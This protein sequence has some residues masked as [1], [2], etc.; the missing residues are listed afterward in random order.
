[1]NPKDVDF[2]L[3][4]LLMFKPNKNTSQYGFVINFPHQSLKISYE[5][6][7]TL[8][9]FV[10]QNLALY[11]VDRKNFYINNN[12]PDITL[13]EI[14]DKMVA[15]IFPVVFVVNQ[16]L[17]IVNLENHK[18]IVAR[19]EQ[20]KTTMASYYIGEV[21]E[22][23]MTNFTNHYSNPSLLAKQLQKDWWYFI[24]FPTLYQYYGLKLYT[25]KT[26]TLTFQENKLDLDI[27]YEIEKQYS[28]T[29]KLILNLKSEPNNKD[30]AAYQARYMLNPEANTIASAVGSIQYLE[31]DTLEIVQFECYQLNG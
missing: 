19:C 27:H 18:E 12:P 23:I 13:Y 4:G 30:Q 25:Q 20:T 1:M 10:N 29:G 11:E 5:L 24:L 2:P 3:H 26:A 28:Q 7:I 31:D 6:S 16:N 8:K 14:A 15:A 22:K 21:S 17:E 9:H